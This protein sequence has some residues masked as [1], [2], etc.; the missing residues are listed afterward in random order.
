MLANQK[1]ALSFNQN[2]NRKSLL[3]N[4]SPSNNQDG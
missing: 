2:N 3:L 4:T 1:K